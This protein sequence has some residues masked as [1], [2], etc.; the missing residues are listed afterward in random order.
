[1]TQIRRVNLDRDDLLAV[2]PTVCMQFLRP[3][4]EAKKQDAM[5]T[6]FCLLFDSEYMAQYFRTRWRTHAIAVRQAQPSISG[7]FAYQALVASIM[8]D[9]DEKAHQ[10][11]E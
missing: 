11:R 6:G 1:M 4:I 8:I 10:K 5:W 3:V 2:S 7:G 9:I